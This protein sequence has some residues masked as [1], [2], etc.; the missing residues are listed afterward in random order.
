MP[1]PYTDSYR[2]VFPGLPLAVI[3]FFA[4]NNSV[5]QHGRPGTWYVRSV[6]EFI[7]HYQRINL[8]PDLVPPQPGAV[9]EICQRLCKAGHLNDFGV[10]DS[11]GLDG[12]SHRYGATGTGS[13]AGDFARRL[14][15][16]VYG[17]P[18]IYDTFKPSVV[19][20]AHTSPKD[21]DSIG[22]GFAIRVDALL[23]AAHC[24]GGAKCLAIRGVSKEMLSQATYFRSKKEAVD[25]ALVLLPGPI[26]ADRPHLEMSQPVILQDVMA[27]G[28]PNVPGFQTEVAAEKAM[29]SN[30]LTAV[31]GAIASSPFEIFAGAELL[32]IT[33]RVRGGFSG[34]PILND[35]GDYVGV[36][37]RTPSHETDTSWKKA[38]QQYDNL[39]YGTAIPSELVRLFLEDI[40]R[41]AGTHA[42][43]MT[44]SRIEFRNFL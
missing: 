13:E 23:T 17:F 40:D 36:V 3:R 43:R 10:G 11:F 22:T 26:F 21:A 27:L 38:S 9:N 44:M 32:L 1:H 18:C 19:P 24:I 2:S 8:T 25:L 33:A 30:R 20:I 7:E 35:K 14:D 6:Q 4:V 34:G 16:A 42:T 37:S 12:L 39:G 15:C 41:G 5:Q 28:Y 29:I 31:R